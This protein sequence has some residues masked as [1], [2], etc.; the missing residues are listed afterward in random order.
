[1]VALVEGSDAFAVHRTYLLPDGSGKAAIDPDKMMLG[2]VAG[3]AVRL[4][5]G[6]GGLVVA[7]GIETALSLACGL[8]S[9]PARYG[10]LSRQAGFNRCV[11]PRHRE[12]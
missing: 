11:C 4:T 9:G 8:L 3:G 5:D 7:E 10:R 6:P 12:S 1:M 2:A